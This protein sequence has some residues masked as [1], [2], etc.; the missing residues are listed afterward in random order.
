MSMAKEE[1]ATIG[2]GCFW[3]FEAL[4]Q[5]LNGVSS[6]VSGYSGGHTTH[7]T[8]EQVYMGDTGHAEV[9]Q[10]A[11]DPNVI[12]YRQL[13]EIF[14]T[15]HNPTTLN[16]QGNDVGTEYRSIILYHDDTQ[17]QTAEDVISKFARKL[18]KDPIT[19]ELVPFQIFWPAGPEHQDYYNN[20]RSTGYCTVIID[21]KVA[22]LRQKF[23]AMLKPVDD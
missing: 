8:T 23:A 4:Y 11:F 14:F 7:P 5:R 19:T 15:M 9:V 21:P 22:K 10:I 18:W 16:R 2:G 3:C 1:L 13:L 17:K 6:V 20:N 12:S